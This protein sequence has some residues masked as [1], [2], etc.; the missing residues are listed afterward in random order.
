MK[1]NNTIFCYYLVFKP[2]IGLTIINN[3]YYVIIIYIIKIQNKI[4]FSYDWSHLI[5][6]ERD[7][8]R[9]GNC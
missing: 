3:I 7:V 6:K 2:Y 4:Y 8:M 9:P 1:V 5:I